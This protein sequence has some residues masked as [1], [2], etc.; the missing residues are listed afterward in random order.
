MTMQKRGMATNAVGN[1]FQWTFLL[2]FLP[3]ILMAM[4]MVTSPVGLLALTKVCIVTLIIL[5]AC[6][7]V[8]YCIYVELF[9]GMSVCFTET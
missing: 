9:L 6:H 2:F 8:H 5:L 3:R 7:D 4:V 1:Y